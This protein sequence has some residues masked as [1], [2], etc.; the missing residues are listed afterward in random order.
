MRRPLR[1]HKNADLTR[2]VRE[3]SLVDLATLAS[4]I[5]ALFAL[6]GLVI[7]ILT[8][9][10]LSPATVVRNTVLSGLVAVGYA[11]GAMRRN[12]WLFGAT[13]VVQIL[14]FTVIG[15]DAGP[16]ARVAN[17]QHLRADAVGVLVLTIVAYTA[18]LAFLNFTASRYMRV[19]AEIDLAHEVH[20]VL[21]PAIDTRVG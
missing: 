9:G 7:D 18:F 15:G 13:A 14:W 5:F 19:R 8:G 4:G 12:W 16:S 17:L 21:V 1:R 2:L 10:R 6:L 20:Q 3:T 11:F